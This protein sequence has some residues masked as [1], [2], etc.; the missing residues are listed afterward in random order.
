[1]PQVNIRMTRLAHRSKKLF[2]YV[3]SQMWNP[4]VHELGKD[5]H[6]I[7]KGVRVFSQ[8]ELCNILAPE[9]FL[10]NQNCRYSQS[11]ILHMLH[12]KV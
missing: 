8:K 2:I 7:R 9:P 3:T 5:L 1:M 12:K 4:E 11:S 6:L 10:L